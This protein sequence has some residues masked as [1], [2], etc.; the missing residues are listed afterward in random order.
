M[1]AAPFLAGATALLLAGCGSPRAAGTDAA[2]AAC[3]A[4]PVAKGVDDVIGIRMGM[5]LA[6]VKAL[7]KCSNGGFR[8]DEDN[9]GFPLPALPDGK[10]PVTKLVAKRGKIDGCD[11]N[12]PTTVT[13]CVV[14]HPT[15]THVDERVHV[16]FAGMPGAEKVIAVMREIALADGAK[17]AAAP[18]LR[19]LV[20]KY[21]SQPDESRWG[22]TSRL[23]WVFDGRG[24][25]MSPANQDFSLCRDAAGFG[26]DAPSN[27]RGGCRRTVTAWVSTSYD[28]PEIAD[29]YGVALVD[30]DAASKAIDA[31]AA[32]I[33]AL[34]A[35]PSRTES[36]SMV[37]SMNVTL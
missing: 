14:E 36:E 11:P 16:Y 10:R 35:G 9:G 29:S 19:D 1:R 23:A 7:L 28:K 4:T 24:Q 26:S 32:R 33:G 22:S 2:R 13:A 37:T 12:D 17:V 20:A 5:D 25:R 31:T 15:F 30:Q 8:F 27:L 18:I 6:A 34:A 21:G 3:A